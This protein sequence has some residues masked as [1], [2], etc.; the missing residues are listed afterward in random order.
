MIIMI[1]SIHACVSS[2]QGQGKTFINYDWVK[3]QIHDNFGF[4]PYPGTLNLLLNSS[5]IASFQL[6]KQTH[7]SL[8]I[9][10]NPDECGSLCY[11][12]LINNILGIV[13]IPQVPNYP[14]QQLEI[15][16]PVNLRKTLFLEDGDEVELVF[17]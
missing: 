12:I 10:S 16:A 3:K 8:L 1:F 11:P 14:N 5:T 13:V 7:E 4:T 17:Q 2:G 15:V 6:F 9:K